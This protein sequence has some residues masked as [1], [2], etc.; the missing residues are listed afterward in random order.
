MSAAAK[1]ANGFRWRTVVV[2]TSLRDVENEVDKCKVINRPG[3]F[4][5]RIMLIS[6][7]PP[8]AH[9]GELWIK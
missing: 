3:R 2:A 4:D 7:D 1:S 8:H 9:A 5:G 6:P